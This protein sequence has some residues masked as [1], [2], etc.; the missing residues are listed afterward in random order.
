MD[1]DD[2]PSRLSLGEVEGTWNARW[3]AAST[4]IT[5]RSKEYGTLGKTLDLGVLSSGEALALLCSHRKPA[6]SAE[7]SAAQRIVDLLGCHPL[8]VEVAGSYLAQGVE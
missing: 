2:V 3:A 5:T 8:A 1:L 4:L 7:Q 6:N